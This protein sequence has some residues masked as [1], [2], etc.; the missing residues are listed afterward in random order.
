MAVVGQGG[1]DGCGDGGV[2]MDDE[3]AH[4]VSGSMAEAGTSE[5]ALCGAASK[6]VASVAAGLF[7]A[8][9]VGRTSSTFSMWL[10]PTGERR[11]ALL[12]ADRAGQDKGTEAVRCRR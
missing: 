2:V 4:G 5:T 9:P 1:A 6:T 8:G 12:V 11:V 3:D 10:K 7:P